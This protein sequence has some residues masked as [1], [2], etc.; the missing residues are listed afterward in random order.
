MARAQAQYLRIYLG[1]VT[2]ERWQ[3]YYVN[4]TVTW[5]GQPWTYQP[6]SADGITVG[7]V[8]SEASIT[9]TVP[10]TTNMIQILLPSLDQGRL[11]ELAIYEFDP[12]FNNSTPQSGQVQIAAFTGEIVSINGTF[13]NLEIELGS[14]LSPIGAQVPPRSFTSRL[15]GAPC[16]L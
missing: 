5:Q 1:S 3:S 9:L 12:N 14:S 2:Y 10:A 7:K 13:T 16:R 15:I 6:F 4:Q 11:A 8:E